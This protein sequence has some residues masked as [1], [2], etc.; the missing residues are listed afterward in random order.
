MSF[1]WTPAYWQS[2]REANPYRKYKSDRDRSLTVE[3][4]HLEDGESVL[5]VGCGYGWITEAL[6]GAAKI[7]WTGLDRSESMVAQL[8]TRLSAYRPSAFVGDACRLPF[9]ANSFDKVLCTG[10]LMHVTD[11]HA[12]LTE[13]A[14]VLKPGGLLVCSVNNAISPYSLPVRFH[15]SSKKGFTQNFRLPGTY[16]GYFRQLGLRVR[17]I[18]GDGLFVTVPISIGPVSFPPKFAFGFLRAFDRWAV[19]RLPWLAYEIWFTAVKQQ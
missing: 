13:I 9:P 16:R 5:E 10:V 6:L 12:A 19:E 7:R 18:R 15:N 17:Q 14:R 11:D 2:W 1:E 4:L 8:R 3:E